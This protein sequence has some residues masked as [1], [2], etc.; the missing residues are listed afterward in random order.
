MHITAV[1]LRAPT[2]RQTLEEEEEEEEEIDLLISLGVWHAWGT[3]NYQPV[4]VFKRFRPLAGMRDRSFWKWKRQQERKQRD[5][6][7]GEKGGETNQWV[8]LPVFTHL[9]QSDPVKGVLLLP[10]LLGV[11]SNGNGKEVLWDYC[12]CARYINMIP[13]SHIVYFFSSPFRTIEWKCIR[14]R[15]FQPVPLI[16]GWRPSLELEDCGEREKRRRKEGKKVG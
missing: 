12:V 11:V 16:S 7:Y 1:P 10:V 15:I 5:C 6:K 14:N 4:Q 8:T 13:L 3:S 2:L 9:F